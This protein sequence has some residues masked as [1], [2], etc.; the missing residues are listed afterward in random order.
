MNSTNITAT[1]EN[2]ALPKDYLSNGYKTT[3]GKCDARYVA[4][5]AAEIAANLAPMDKERFRAFYR[6]IDLNARNPIDQ[7]QRLLHQLATRAYKFVQRNQA[8]KIFYEFMKRNAEAV[9]DHKSYNDFIDHMEA[10][11][12]YMI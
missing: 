6:E 1:T 11:Y 10:I 2:T 12:C 7:K 3:E 4:S 8:P 5:Y 9:T